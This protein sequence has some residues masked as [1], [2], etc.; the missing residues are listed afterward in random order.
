MGVCQSGEETHEADKSDQID[1]QIDKEKA[2]QEYKILLLGT[3]THAPF[4]LFFNV[5]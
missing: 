2:I 5:W 1:R 4:L 3:Y